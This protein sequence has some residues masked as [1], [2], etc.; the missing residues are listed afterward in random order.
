MASVSLTPG[1]GDR[2][3][4]QAVADHFEAGNIALAATSL[5]L[6]WAAVRE[7]RPHDLVATL[8]AS[9][10]SPA[11]PRRELAGKERMSLA[12]FES[13]VRDGFVVRA[14]DGW[15]LRVP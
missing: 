11:D 12:A 6:T 4:L 3:W 5:T 7:G 13:L 15:L 9:Y 2:Q 8:L 10:D 1:L 14:A